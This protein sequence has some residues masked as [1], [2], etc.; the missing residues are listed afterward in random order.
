MNSLALKHVLKQVQEATPELSS[1]PP[2]SVDWSNRATKTCHL[3]VPWL[4]AHSR[5]LA[6][7]LTGV[8]NSPHDVRESA[9][10]LIDRFLSETARRQSSADSKLLTRLRSSLDYEEL[11]ISEAGGMVVSKLIERFLIEKSVRWKLESNGASDYPDLFL[12]D[13]DYSLLPKFQRG[14]KQ[15]YG[16]AIKGK[17]HRPVRVPDGLEVKTCKGPFAVDCHHAHAG[18][19]LVVLFSRA[20][21]QF[22]VNDIQ[23]AFMRS[24]LYRITVPASPTTTLKASFN[25]QP[26]V[27]ILQS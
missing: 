20:K 17:S 3:L 11:L 21:N 13:N 9:K 7:Y 23:V 25:R 14:T 19:H 22:R 24:E 8:M 1:T 4:E 16:A 2:T 26:F 6:N 15:V 18:L 5:D 12:R 10:L 27:S